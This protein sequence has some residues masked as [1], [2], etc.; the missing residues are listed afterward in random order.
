MTQKGFRANFSL[1]LHP[2]YRQQHP[3]DQILTMYSTPNT[4]IV[5][6]SYTH[7]GRQVPPDNIAVIQYKSL[8]IHS[9]ATLKL[10]PFMQLASQPIMCQQCNTDI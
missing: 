10:T 6:I 2:R 3:A 8:S 1:P 7:I 9:K 5:T 4:T